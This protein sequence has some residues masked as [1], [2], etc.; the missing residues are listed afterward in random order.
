MFFCVFFVVP[1]RKT[2]L[3]LPFLL[4]PSS[5]RTSI[6]EGECP[7]LSPNLTSTSILLWLVLLRPS[8]P[9]PWAP[10]SQL[11]SFIL[12]WMSLPVSAVALSLCPPSESFQSLLNEH[13]TDYPSVPIPLP[14]ALLHSVSCHWGVCL[15]LRGVL[16][17]RE[18]VLH[19]VGA[20]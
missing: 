14:A 10:Q 16:N 2:S 20:L 4:L 5:W 19:T 3:I 18:D 17:A 15:S 12:R 13:P 7:F 1:Q 11:I 6:H 9:V 8:L